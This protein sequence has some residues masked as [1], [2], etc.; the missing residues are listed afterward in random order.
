[1]FNNSLPAS[2]ELQ[3]AVLEDQ[4]VKRVASRGVSGKPV[5]PAQVA[6]WN[7]LQSQSGRVHVFRQHVTIQNVDRSAYQ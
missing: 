5:S 3:M 1:M 6:Q 2:V 4:A 7:Y